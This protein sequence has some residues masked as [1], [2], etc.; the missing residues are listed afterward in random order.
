[1]RYFLVCFRGNNGR[2]QRNEIGIYGYFLTQDGIVNGIGP[3]MAESPGDGVMKEA[4][5][6]VVSDTIL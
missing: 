6:L 2:R 4:A 3:G 1:M 5:E